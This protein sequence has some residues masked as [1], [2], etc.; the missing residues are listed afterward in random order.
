MLRTAAAA[1]LLPAAALAAGKEESAQE[2]SLPAP[3]A[4]ERVVAFLEAERDIIDPLKERTVSLLADLGSIRRDYETA[5]IPSRDLL[6][7]RERTRRELADSFKEYR[8]HLSDFR[9]RLDEYEQL[10]FVSAFGR[11]MK[12]EAKL[13]KVADRLNNPGSARAYSRGHEPFLREY[14]VDLAEEQAA[15]EALLRSRRRRI[16]GAWGGAALILSAALLYRRLRP[17][18]GLGGK[19]L[20][21]PKLLVFGEHYM[22]G[23][24][25]GKND[26]GTLYDGLDVRN[27]SAVRV[28][29]LDPSSGVSESRVFALAAA[30]RTAASI[31]DP[32]FTGLSLIL[33]E[34]GRLGLVTQ[35]PRGTPVAELFPSGSRPPLSTAF[36]ILDKTSAALDRLHASGIFHGGVCPANILLS[37]DGSVQIGGLG[38]PCS[39]DRTFQPLEHPCATCSS[40]PLFSTGASKLAGVG[41]SCAKI[42]SSGPLNRS[43]DIFSLSACAYALMTGRSPF[44]GPDLA[45][46]KRLLALPPVLAG[47]PELPTALEDALRRGLSPD[48]ALRFLSCREAVATL[49]SLT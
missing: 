16:G 29:I 40:G 6:K 10:S 14:E 3:T 41:S 43:M 48:P 26:L 45:E 27:D 1:C 24:E 46:Q 31:K 25:V 2:E 44:P 5:W 34:G 8:R 23:S 42:D 39:G 12:G 36:D 32:R 13:E 38:L 37:P 33:R 17:V 9:S 22:L 20:P 49:R 15:F 30:A 4:Q 28:W 19:A 18:L 11:F 35:A 21:G 47:R 7:K